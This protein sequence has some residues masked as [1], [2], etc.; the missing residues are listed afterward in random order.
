MASIYVGLLFIGIGILVKLFPNLIA[1]YNNLSHK[2]K[3][4]ALTNGLPTFAFIVSGMMGLI[5]FAGHYLGLWMDMPSVGR[6]LLIISSLAGSVILIV[7]GNR[8]T[9]KKNSIQ[10]TK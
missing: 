6:N 5:I 7:F 2:E 4:N 10:K 3:E 1:G 8:F 9:V